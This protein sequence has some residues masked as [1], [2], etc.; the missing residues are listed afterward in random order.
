MPTDAAHYLVRQGPRHV[1]WGFT[2]GP[3]DMTR[4]GR[5]LFVHTCRFT[6]ELA[7]GKK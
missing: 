3:D 5:Q 2:A 4:E 7:A 1:L 6:Q